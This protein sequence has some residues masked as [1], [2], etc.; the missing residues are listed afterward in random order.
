MTV[1]FA[2]LGARTNF[3]LLDGA[4]HPAE[5]VETAAML[6]HAGIGVCDRNSLAGVVRAHVAAKDLK[7][8]FVVGTRLVLDDGA[9]YLTWP[10]DR[11]SYGRLTKLLSLG[12]MRAPKG[13]CQISRAEMLDHADGW[14]MAAVPPS[15]PDARFAGRLLADA[16][17]LR[18]RLARPLLCSASVIYDGADRHRLETLTAIGAAE[19]TGLLAT[20]DPRYHHPDRR[21]LADVLT[22]IRLGV[23]VDRIGFAA[24]R[25]GERCLKSAM[26]MGRL[27]AAHPEALDNTIRVLDACAGF[28]LDQLRHEYPR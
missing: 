9:T 25:N 14:V 4:S 21:R 10:T 5:M 18:D 7:L 23:P 8:R 1:G 2:E 20:T 26:E 12:R 15:L 13:Q 17:D 22:A 11:A 24:D 3:T 16:R 27:F 6:G 28:S 19:G